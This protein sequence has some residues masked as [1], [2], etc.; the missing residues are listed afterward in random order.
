MNVRRALL[1]GVHQHLVHIAHDRCVIGIRLRNVRAAVLVGLCDFQIIEIG[2]AHADAHAGGVR[3]VRRHLHHLGQLVLLH[4]DGLGGHAGSKL[5]LVE[6]RDVGRVGNTD[7]DFFAALEQRYR[8]VF[9]DQ[10]VADI[11]E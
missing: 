4:H 8:A 2:I 6:C 3:C 7:I 5:E 9:A 11:A 10:L 1:N